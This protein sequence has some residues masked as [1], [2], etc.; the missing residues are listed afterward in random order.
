MCGV[1]A[2][3]RWRHPTRGVVPPAE[4]IPLAEELGLIGR[5]DDFVLDEACRQ[6]AA[7]LARRRLARRTSRMAVNISGQR[8][9]R[10]G[11]RRSTSAR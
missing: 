1:E 5:I 10:S 7:W 6:L 9:R 3:V 2:L 8:A 11:L 4:F